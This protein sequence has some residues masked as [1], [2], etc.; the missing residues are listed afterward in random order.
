MEKEI[1]LSFIGFRK[2]GKEMDA[3]EAGCIAASVSRGASQISEIS[4]LPVVMIR[5]W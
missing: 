3:L 2:S 4:L 1:A 5:K